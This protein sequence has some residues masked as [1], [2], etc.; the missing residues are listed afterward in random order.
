MTAKRHDY[1]KYKKEI[2]QDLGRSLKA[3]NA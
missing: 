3:T 1:Q 2:A